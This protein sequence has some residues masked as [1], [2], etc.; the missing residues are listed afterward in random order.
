MNALVVACG[1]PHES[2]G[3]G[4]AVSCSLTAYERFFDRVEFISLLDVPGATPQNRFPRTRFTVIGTRQASL[5]VRFARTIFKSHPAVVADLVSRVGLLRLATALRESVARSSPDV[6]IFETLAA[7]ATLLPLRDAF[8]GFMTVLRSM[9]VVYRG[10][11]KVAD[12]S[13]FPLRQAWRHETARMRRLEADVLKAVDVV[14]GITEADA[15]HYRLD[16]ARACDGVLGIYVDVDRFASIPAGDPLT[17]VHLGGV[18]SRK[19]HGLDVFLREC[20]QLVLRNVPDARLLLA[21]RGSEKYHGAATNVTALGFV[22]ADLDVIAR[23]AIFLNPQLSGSGIKVKSI[24]ALAARRV[25]VSTPNGVQGVPGVCGRDYLVGDTPALLASA[26]TSVLRQPDL[27]AQIAGNGYSLAKATFSRNA[28]LESGEKLFRH[29]F[30][31]MT[32]SRRE[33]RTP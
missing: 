8:S 22:P 2:S 20:W 17:V 10:F 24:H 26:L 25:L 7:A 28:F 18:D 31:N 12:D 11:L 15:E 23:G 6:V 29:S 14:W 30:G 4:I 21:G 27:A 19:G 13:P 9:D 33:N 1:V 5:A 32:R 16:F 3:Y